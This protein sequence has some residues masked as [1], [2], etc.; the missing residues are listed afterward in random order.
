MCD[1]FL[2]AYGEPPPRHTRC[3][4]YLDAESAGDYFYPAPPLLASP[5]NPP[6]CFSKARLQVTAGDAAAAAAESEVLGGYGAG[7]VIRR[8]RSRG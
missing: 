8:A 5:Q 3:A 2:A 7:R 4:V 6:L 1:D